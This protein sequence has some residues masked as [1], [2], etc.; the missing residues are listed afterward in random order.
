MKLVRIA[1]SQQI[2]PS[3]FH[4]FKPLAFQ[5]LHHFIPSEKITPS[6][7]HHISYFLPLQPHAAHSYMAV[8]LREGNSSKV[9]PLQPIAAH[10]YMAIL[11]R[12][13]IPQKSPLAAHSYMAILDTGGG[14][15]LNSPPIATHCSPLLRCDFN[16][17]VIPQISSHCSP[18]HT[19]FHPPL[20]K[21]PPHSYI[22]LQ[23]IDKL[24]PP[25]LTTNYPPLLQQITPHSY[26]KYGRILGTTFD[27]GFRIIS[28]VLLKNTHEFRLGKETGPESNSEENCRAREQ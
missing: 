10:S 1:P 2:T 8:L 27:P 7:L 21:I 5:L 26:N 23:P 28:S 20:N 4:H 15:F 18:T 12:G 3:L 11:V 24:P 22:N 14:Y 16:Q 6:I 17:G 13:I 25:P 9:I 19:S